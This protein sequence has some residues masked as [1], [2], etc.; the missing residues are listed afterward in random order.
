MLPALLVVGQT[1]R[2]PGRLLC[3]CV[4]RLPG[5]FIFFV[6][7]ALMHVVVVVVVSSTLHSPR[8]FDTYE[9]D[10]TN[11]YVLPFFHPCQSPSTSRGIVRKTAD[12]PHLQFS[13]N[14][15]SA[16]QL[17]FS[18]IGRSATPTDHTN[19]QIS[20]VFAQLRSDLDSIVFPETCI[21]YQYIMF[22]YMLLLICIH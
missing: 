21:L 1:I 17:Q 11:R 5:V 10:F 16:T 9:R 8:E 2:P 13:V 14:G 4:R 3:R 20:E 6:L 15:R 18:V 12:R 19:Q 7:S 22:S